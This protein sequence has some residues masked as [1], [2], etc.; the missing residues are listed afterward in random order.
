MDFTSTG[1]VDIRKWMAM[2]SRFVTSATMVS[3]MIAQL[4]ALKT[5]SHTP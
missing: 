1:G 4:P 5:S 3:S 2:I